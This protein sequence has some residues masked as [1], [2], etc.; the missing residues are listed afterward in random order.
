MPLLQ[1]RGLTLPTVRRQ[2]RKAKRRLG[3]R[4]NNFILRTLNHD[5]S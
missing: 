1:A 2:A 3:P 5:V 4:L